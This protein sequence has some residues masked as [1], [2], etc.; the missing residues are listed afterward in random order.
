MRT[1]PPGTGR[2]PGAALLPLALGLAFCLNPARILAQG[3]TVYAVDTVRAVQPWPPH[4]EYSFPRLVIPARPEVAERIN[5]HLAID[6]LEAD[7]DTAGNDLFSLVWGDAA[8]ARTPSLYDL[9]WEVHQPLPEVVDFELT[10]EGCGAYCE[11][12]TRHYLYDLRDGS[13]LAFDS[14]FTPAG[15]VAVNDTLDKLWRSTLRAYVDSLEIG[16]S[17]PDLTPADK[18]VAQLVAVLYLDCL[19]ERVDLA[20]YVEDVQPLTT[21]MRFFIARCAAHVNQNLDELDPVSFQLQ[22]GWLL[23]RIRP[24]FADLLKAR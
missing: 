4:A 9:T 20:P 6:F 22:Y 21:G 17:G 16:L 2:I 1:P 14:L 15:L 12:F 10:G 8:T 7:P 3:R 5:R 18:E 23:T 11:G 24:Q 19:E 13:Y